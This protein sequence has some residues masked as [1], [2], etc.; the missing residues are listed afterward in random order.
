MD[1][2]STPNAN[3]DVNYSLPKNACFRNLQ[4]LIDSVGYIIALATRCI[5]LSIFSLTLKLVTAST[6]SIAK[7]YKRWN[8]LAVTYFLLTLAV[9]AE[10]SPSQQNL[11][12]DYSERAL[13]YPKDRYADS[14]INYG[15]FN[16]NAYRQNAAIAEYQ[17]DQPITDSEDGWSDTESFSSAG[18]SSASLSSSTTAVSTSSSSRE[19]QR[20]FSASGSLQ[21]PA[22]MYL[23]KVPS[24]SIS[25]LV[26]PRS[27]TMQARQGYSLLPQVAR[28]NPTLTRD[29]SLLVPKRMR[30]EEM[31][32]MYTLFHPR[33]MIDW[34]AEFSTHL[35]VELWQRPR[36]SGLFKRKDDC[37]PWIRTGRL[38]Q[39][40]LRPHERGSSTSGA[41]FR[42]LMVE[43]AQEPWLIFKFG[44]LHPFIRQVFDKVPEAEQVEE[45]NDHCPS[46]KLR[47]KKSKV[48]LSSKTDGIRV[49][50]SDLKINQYRL[51]FS[52]YSEV[53]SD[54][55]MQK[56]DV[57]LV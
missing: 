54:Y 17:N 6:F 55:I 19:L 31:F 26:T 40:L 57:V 34:R 30:L 22:S 11:E 20:L 10:W 28:F 5:L 52:I 24:H 7:M 12:S 25:Q 49:T 13:D 56:N 14:H 45:L 32:S 4:S 37:Q 8:L 2:E 3:V 42:G 18:P 1:I 27:V 16:R 41:V 39:R 23:Y 43:N 46:S 48:K 33:W 15:R 29:P 38:T 35:F 53:F 47:G 21:V 51:R 44:L 36:Y 9:S 50:E